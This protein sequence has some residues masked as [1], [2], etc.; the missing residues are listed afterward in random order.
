MEYQDTKKVKDLSY[1][2]V[3]KLKNY[4]LVD[5]LWER[6]VGWFVFEDDGEAENTL[7]AFING[8]LV[9]NIK[10]YDESIKTLKQMLYSNN[11]K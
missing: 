3:L 2:G 9:G 5:I 1:A 8:D 11:N 4:K 10:K 7:R 6:E